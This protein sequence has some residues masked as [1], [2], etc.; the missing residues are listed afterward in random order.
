MA[1]RCQYDGCTQEVAPPGSS[2][3]HDPSQIQSLEQTPSFVYVSHIRESS[4]HISV[5]QCLLLHLIPASKR[6]SRYPSLIQLLLQ[7]RDLRQALS[8]PNQ[9]FHSLL[10]LVRQLDA[11]DLR[12]GRGAVDVRWDVESASFDAHNLIRNIIGWRFGQEQYKGNDVG[13]TYLRS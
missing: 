8:I 9:L 5:L 3:L 4:R 12:T 13:D 6:T 11:G 10:L 7:S 1:P 2:S